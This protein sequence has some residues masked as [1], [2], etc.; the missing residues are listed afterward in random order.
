[1]SLSVVI[2]IQSLPYRIENNRVLEANL[3]RASAFGQP[4]RTPP[5]SPVLQPLRRFFRTP[6][7]SS[8]VQ[9][10]VGCSSRT[11]IPPFAPAFGPG[12]FESSKIDPLS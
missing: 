11:A 5:V 3:T 2:F 4:I 9:P 1:M 7:M 6:E 10:P 8:P 12:F